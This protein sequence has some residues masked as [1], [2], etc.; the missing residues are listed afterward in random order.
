MQSIF[1]ALQEG[2]KLFQ[3][4]DT[5]KGY[6]IFSEPKENKPKIQKEPKQKKKQKEKKVKITNKLKNL[7]EKN[8]KLVRMKL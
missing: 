5:Q 6:I 7:K 1:K 3:T 8:Q 2:E 4:S